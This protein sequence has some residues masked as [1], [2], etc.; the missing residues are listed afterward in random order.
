MEE[1]KTNEIIQN[2]ELIA[3]T[4]FPYK[5]NNNLSQKGKYTN[6]FIKRIKRNSA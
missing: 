4:K 6:L 1:N 5:Y 2:K 3:N